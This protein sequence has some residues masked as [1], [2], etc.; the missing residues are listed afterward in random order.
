M[1]FLSN[2]WNQITPLVTENKDIVSLL[3][4]PE[5][6][7]FN[8]QYFQAE[9]LELWSYDDLAVSIY[10]KDDLVQFLSISPNSKNLLVN[11][12][13]EWLNVLGRS[14]EPSYIK[15]NMGKNVC[16]KIFAQKG[17]AL[18]A[19]CIDY[20]KAKFGN[21]D[22]IEIFPEMS[23]EKYLRQFAKDAVPLSQFN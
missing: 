7:F 4:E 5:R 19:E 12:A 3:G 8:V 21:L 10:S 17:L 22:L 15:S 6:K 14:E 20:N 2:T 11:K 18:H 16:I 9:D 23:F 1:I 13:G